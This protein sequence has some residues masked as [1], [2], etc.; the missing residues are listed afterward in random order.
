MLVGV[1]R[2]G[3]CYCGPILRQE[4]MLRYIAWESYYYVNNWKIKEKKL[5]GEEK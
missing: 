3:T 2:W 4:I 1:G 5:S